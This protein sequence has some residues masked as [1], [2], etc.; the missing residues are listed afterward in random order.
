MFIPIAGSEETDIAT[1]LNRIISSFTP[2]LCRSIPADLIWK[3]DL[4]SHGQHPRH[5]IICV[6]GP[7]STL[8]SQ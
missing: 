2:Q 4:V 8:Q 7:R 6:A 1:W 3:A 5:T